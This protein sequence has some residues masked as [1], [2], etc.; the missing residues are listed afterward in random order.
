MHNLQSY[1]TTKKK[2]KKT[3]TR[4]YIHAY[5]TYSSSIAHVG[6]IPPTPAI[7]SQQIRK[8]GTQGPSQPVCP[9]F[10]QYFLTYL[11]IH[12][13]KV[14]CKNPVDSRAVGGLSLSPPTQLDSGGHMEGREENPKHG[15]LTSASCE[16]G[17][18]LSGWAHDTRSARFRKSFGGGRGVVAAR[19]EEEL[20]AY[21]LDGMA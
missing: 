13:P 21:I 1:I 11:R 7:L 19:D 4:T 3:Q 17:W 10:D 5:A 8:D 16:R 9:G 18:V 12:D 15:Q 6:K 2:P 14:L 20:A